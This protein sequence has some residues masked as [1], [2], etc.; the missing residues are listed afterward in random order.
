[1]MGRAAAAIDEIRDLMLVKTGGDDR[2]IVFQPA[3]QHGNIPQ[4]MSLDQEHAHAPRHRI[5]LRD[6]IRRL[7]AFDGG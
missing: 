6:P 3:H 7:D 1:M 5:D 4:P 2:M